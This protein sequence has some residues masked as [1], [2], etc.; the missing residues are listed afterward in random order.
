M[1]RI[2]YYGWWAEQVLSKPG[3]SNNILS[4][5]DCNKIATQKKKGKYKQ[6][7]SNSFVA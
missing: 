1:N 7:L 4:Q 5:W 3:Y 6:Y 2:L